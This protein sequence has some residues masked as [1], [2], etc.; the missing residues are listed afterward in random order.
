M[1][2]APD[3]LEHETVRRPVEGRPRGTPPRHGCRRLNWRRSRRRSVVPVDVVPDRGPSRRDFFSPDVRRRPFPA[4]VGLGDPT[5]TRP[6]NLTR[7]VPHKQ[8]LSMAESDSV[9]ELSGRPQGGAPRMTSGGPLDSLL[10]GV[11]SAWSAH[12]FPGIPVARVRRG[13]MWAPERP[14]TSFCARAGAAASFPLLE[15]PAT[16]SGD[17]LAAITKRKAGGPDPAPEPGE[18]RRRPGPSANRPSSTGTAPADEG[19]AGFLDRGPGPRTD[20]AS[21]AEGYEQTARQADRP[22]AQGGPPCAGWR[23]TPSRRSPS[24]L[25]VAPRTVNPQAPGDPRPSGKR[26]GARMSRWATAPTT[27]ASR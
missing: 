1:Q 19:I 5:T 4:M 11:W 22:D 18:A 7:D 14:S 23:V 24:P 8:G 20:A 13:R 3:G 15:G 26:E 9:D 17:F 16:T 6:I 10:S 25:D 27:N 12:D 21:F 2:K